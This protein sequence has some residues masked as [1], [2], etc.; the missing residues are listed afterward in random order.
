MPVS[1]RGA[2]RGFATSGT[3][4]LFGVR[5]DSAIEPSLQVAGRPIELALTPIGS[6]IVRISI[7]PLDAGRAGPI[8]SD[9]ALVNENWGAPVARL[10]SVSAA[11]SFTCAAGRVEVSAAPLAVRI[12]A[13]DGRLVQELRFEVR[14]GSFAFSVGSGCVL[15]LGEGGPQFDR[16]G[17]ADRMRN[18]QGGYRLRTHGGRVPVPWLIG[19][20]GWAMFVHQPAGWFDLT[21]AEGRFSPTHAA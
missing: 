15:G 3:A 18:G 13:Q 10:S 8:P 9:G 6:R 14:T 1:R 2:L 11:R 20:A 17:S 4:A 5:V 21:G 16:R 7:L 19:T 12:E